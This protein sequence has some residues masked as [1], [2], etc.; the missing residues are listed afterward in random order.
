MFN[1]RKVY[2]D[3]AAY[4]PIKKEVANSINKLFKL[5]E[6]SMIS[7]AYSSHFVGLEAKKYFD[8]ARAKVA[9]TLETKSNEI[10]F[11]SG[12]TES[13]QLILRGVIDAAL[14][15]GIPFEKQH[16]IFS[17]I[18][19]SSN[20]NL[21]KRYESYGI[22]FT[23]LK[24]NNK[25]IID[26]RDVYENLTPNT[27]LVSMI[28][29]NNEMGSIQ[30]IRKISQRIRDYAKENNQHIHIHTDSAQAR[31]QNIKPSVLNV[32]SLIIDG[33]KI[34]GPSG[35]AV[36][37]IKKG[38]QIGKY[39][40][41]ESIYF[42]IR[43]GTLNIPLI[44]GMA[45]AVELQYTKLE[46]KVLK[47]KELRLYF[48]NKI[49]EVLV[50]YKPFMH[51]AGYVEQ[52]KNFEFDHLAPHIFNINFAGADHRYLSF[53]LSE[54]GVYVTTRTACCELEN[55]DT[56]HVLSA[57]NPQ[58]SAQKKDG[59]RFSV[60]TGTIKRDLDYAVS[61]LKKNLKIAKN[62]LL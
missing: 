27:V 20:M 46:E 34:H 13:N 31:Y 35:I 15:R 36:L 14:V 12:A 50:D 43:E 6:K 24:P 30:P 10:F 33:I 56:S 48:L 8:K 1:K 52:C 16:I 22:K 62:R 4:T 58:F 5:S 51:G 61:S 44:Y 9:K 41:G 37:Y 38:S 53:L 39:T 55:V 21:I 42:N 40:V 7:N 47:I 29:V 23:T 25:G 32:D 57:I 45:L 18:E 19:H 17:A 59:I 60:S 2:L 54:D 3:N 11:T 26:P 28:F 49:K